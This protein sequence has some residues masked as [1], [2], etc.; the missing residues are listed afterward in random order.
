[1]VRQGRLGPAIRLKRDGVMVSET[2]IGCPLTSGAW[3]RRDRRKSGGG[4]DGT[5]GAAGV[6]VDG[7]FFV[8]GGPVLFLA[9]DGFKVGDVIFG[10]HLYVVE[11]ELG[12]GWI[13]IEDV[14]AFGVDVDEVER[15]WA[16]GELGF[17]AAKELLEYGGIEW[18]E[19]EEQRGCSG[20]MEVERVLLDDFD[21]REAWGG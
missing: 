13:A 1:M 7:A 21:G 17:D 16:S 3:T 4:E 5:A 2:R 19:E 14:G 15:V 20:E 10:R 11:E 9:G 6:A 18:V 12:E 8:A